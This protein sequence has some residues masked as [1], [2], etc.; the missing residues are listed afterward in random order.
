MEHICY[1]CKE[2]EHKHCVGRLTEKFNSS[3][4]C[5]CPTCRI[6]RTPDEAVARLTD[7]ETSWW[8]AASIRDVIANQRAVWFVLWKFGPMKHEDLVDKYCK[9]APQFDLPHQSESG[10]RTRCKE[11]VDKGHARWTGRKEPMRDSG[12]P[13][14]VWEVAYR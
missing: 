10:I 11:L 4:R 1:R 9:V 6:P 5:I 2:G 14:Q 3:W 8:A 7:P 12:L 13:S